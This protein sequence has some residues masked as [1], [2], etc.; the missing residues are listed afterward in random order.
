[1][2]IARS[3]VQEPVQLRIRFE[4]RYYLASGH[5]GTP[6]RRLAIPRRHDVLC[7]RP[8]IA[9]H[10]LVA[11][12]NTTPKGH[13]S[14]ALPHRALLPRSLVG[15]LLRPGLAPAKRSAIS[16]QRAAGFALQFDELIVAEQTRVGSKWPVPEKVSGGTN[17]SSC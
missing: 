7:R 4:V 13:W 9:Y 14:C 3:A 15:L 10:R 8:G 1:M 5:F 11:A 17:S 16:E 12:P 6:Q 2:D